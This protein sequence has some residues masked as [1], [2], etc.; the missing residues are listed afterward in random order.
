MIGLR[1]L[2]ALGIL[3]S[4]RGR[5]EG[6]NHCDA[7][8][9]EVKKQ[10]ISPSCTLSRADAPDSVQVE[11][12]ILDNGAVEFICVEDSSPPATSFM[13]KRKDTYGSDAVELGNGKTLSGENFQSGVYICEVTN[14]IGKSSGSLH[15][16]KAPGSSECLNVCQ[17][18]FL[19]WQWVSSFLAGTKSNP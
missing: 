18:P 4:V 14:P 10:T 11:V 9:G 16:Y 19:C 3:C 2:L 7:S 5:G 6:S 12:R 1:A 17:W 15:F 8:T 13:W